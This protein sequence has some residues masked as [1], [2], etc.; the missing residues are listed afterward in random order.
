MQYW[1]ELIPEERTKA[2][3]ELKTDQAIAATY[4]APRW[5][6]LGQDALLY[7]EGCWSLLLNEDSVNEQY[8]SCTRSGEDGVV[9]GCDFYNRIDKTIEKK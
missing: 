6:S 9:E 7:I 2:K 1:H 8:C 3:Q 5:C 4:K